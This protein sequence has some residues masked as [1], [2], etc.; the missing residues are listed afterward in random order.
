MRK[1]S[2]LIALLI[3]TAAIQAVSA[4][5]FAYVVKNSAGVDNNLLGKISDLGYDYDIVYEANVSSTDFSQY[6]LIIVGNS[7][8]D[9]PS[10][11]PIDQYKSLIINSYDYYKKNLD[12]QLGFSYSSGSLTSPSILQVYD[13]ESPIVQGIN[14][15]FRGYTLTN[16]AVK[17]SYLLGKK[18]TG[19]RI[20]V[21]TQT[22]LANAAIATIDPGVTYLNGKTAEER[23][24]FFGIVDASYWTQDSRTLFA[25]SITWLLEGED[26]DQD[27]FTTDDDCN[28][29]DSSIN[30][31]AEEI[32][33][34]GIDQDCSGSDLNDLDEDGFIAD[35][36]G[37][38]DCDDF[39]PI[40][41]ILNPDPTLNCVNDAPFVESP[42][43]IQVS[44]R[45]LV[46]IPVYAEDPEQDPLFYTINDQRFSLSDN[47]FSWQTS[48]DDSG[49]YYLTFNVS[50]GE[51]TVS[52]QFTLTV[53]NI[54]RPPVALEI[55]ELSWDEDTNITLD[56]SNYFSDPDLDVL[57]YNVE[58]TSANNKIELHTNGSIMTFYAL[59][60]WSGEDYVIFS[61]FD[62]DEKTLS[63]QVILNVNPVNDAPTFNNIPGITMNEDSQYQ[64]NLDNYFHDLDSALSFSV[65]GNLNINVTIN[66]GLALL[67]PVKDWS[68]T[69][70]F[71]FTASDSEFSLDSNPVEVNVAEMPEPPEFSPLDCETDINEDQEYSCILSATDLE[72]DSISFSVQSKNNL[73]CSISDN[74]LSY[75]SYKDYNGGA[76]CTLLTT[77]IDG[78]TS[79]SFNVTIGNVND[80][81]SIIS[82]TPNS[83]N[84]KIPEG[85]SQN[86]TIRA[87]DIDSNYSISWLLGNNTLGS[88]SSYLFNYSR[89]F[90]T[91][92]AL[93]SDSE[94]NISKSWNIN[95]APISE[96]TCSEV[97][98]YVCSANQTCSGNV[99]GVRD[100]D[101]CCSVSCIKAPPSFKDA[102]ACKSLNSTINVD[103]KNPS[104]S[105]EFNPG[106]TISI[107]IKLTNTLD[108]SQNFDVEAHLYD[109]D[110]E[111]S[112]NKEKDTIKIEKNKEKTISLDIPVDESIDTDHKYSLFV[113]AIGDDQ[114]CNQDYVELNVKRAEHSIVISQFDLDQEEVECGD[115][116]NAKLA[117]TNVGSTDELAKISIESSELKINEKANE[118]IEQAGD[119][120]E[121]TKEFYLSIPQ[122]TNGI[123]TVKASVSYTGYFVSESRNITVS[124]ADEKETQK[125]INENPISLSEKQ[126]TQKSSPKSV[127]LIM[128]LSSSL[129]IGFIAYSLFAFSNNQSK[130]TKKK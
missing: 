51:F 99:L 96:F 53:G 8:L 95:V 9:N 15:S 7:N 26:R 63:N 21:S 57:Q 90:Y 20:V 77:D 56:L 78:S 68:G 39:D 94:L 5:D 19:M 23:A 29:R 75:V 54:N 33:Y 107:D 121:I 65:S 89:G 106:E 118:T 10:N 113:K 67:S 110:K 81:P 80:E 28:D 37:G 64:L 128:L 73:N 47:I 116:I 1:L 91:L 30:P 125:T 59:N 66:N 119:K 71:V 85:K 35:L 52:K 117:I 112:V 129:L 25:N 126:S 16:P 98:G 61:V 32:P 87:R 62:G 72:N 111:N 82:F 102:N 92:M 43:N 86:F 120:D 36:A 58:E 76:S 46:E 2:L 115:N 122:N 45:E 105:K 127:L 130:V 83:N 38:D 27:G 41:N 97:S 6:R 13:L 18:P 24:I 11:I 69:E 108:D 109:L 70:T 124:C 50:D 104:S 60:N 49:I 34:D 22:S 55:P 93:I 100:T 114:Q 101:L 44:E 103:I 40:I 42:D 31:N 12:Y 84:I 17:T 4:S 88:E 48:N 79:L 123:Y 3:V 74:A 14:V